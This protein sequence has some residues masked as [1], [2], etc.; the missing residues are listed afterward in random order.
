MSSVL[1]I[2]VL[3]PS[4]QTTLNIVPAKTGIKL[5]YGGDTESENAS[6]MI[7]DFVFCVGKLTDDRGIFST[8]IMK[9]NIIGLIM[10]YTAC[11]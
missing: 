5:S 6:S 8:H 7:Q 2:S 3:I 1:D 10:V 9:V 4:Y 11:I